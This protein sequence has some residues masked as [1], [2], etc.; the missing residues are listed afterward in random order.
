MSTLYDPTLP[1][2]RR[3]RG[4]ALLR[5]TATAA[6]VASAAAVYSACDVPVG[7]LPFPGTPV[8]DGGMVPVGVVPQ[9]QDAF[10]GGGIALPDGFFPGVRVNGDAFV[11]PQSDA[12]LPGVRIN[13]DAFIP[14]KSDAGSPPPPSDAGSPPNVPDGMVCVPGFFPGIIVNPL[15]AG[16]P[17]VV[18]PCPTVD[19]GEPAPESDGFFPGVTIRPDSGG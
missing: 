5:A 7:T 16:F 15:D 3:R 13:S 6:G 17:G 12:F 18:L 2:R 19:A 14:P 10:V 1:H 8:V 4:R 11:P 9:S